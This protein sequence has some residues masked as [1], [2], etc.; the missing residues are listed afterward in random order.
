M[1]LRAS[2]PTEN[3]RMREWEQES[4]N[5]VRAGWQRIGGKESKRASADAGMRAGAFQSMRALEHESMREGHHMHTR[6]RK[7]RSIQA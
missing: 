6:A 4:M 1:S 7:N 5:I 3:K 2:E